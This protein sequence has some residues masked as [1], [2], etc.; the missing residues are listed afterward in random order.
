MKNCQAKLNCPVSLNVLWN[1]DLALGHCVSTS[2]VQLEGAL[3]HCKWFFSLNLRT[4][5]VRN[6]AEKFCVYMSSFRENPNL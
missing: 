1:R 4:L 2:F 6:R 3:S 5:L